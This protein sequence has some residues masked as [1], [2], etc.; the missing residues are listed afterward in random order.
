MAIALQI[1]AVLVLFGYPGC[2][3]EN[4]QKIRTELNTFK[5]NS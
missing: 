4:N 5:K 3:A 1:F 2:A